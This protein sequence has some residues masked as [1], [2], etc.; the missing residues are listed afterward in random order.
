MG[1]LL[2]VGP[3]LNGHSQV[4]RNLQGTSRV[5]S[6]PLRL[7]ES[8]LLYGAFVDFVDDDG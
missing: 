1:R 3:R 5:F 7:C 8:F 2:S 4:A 6:A